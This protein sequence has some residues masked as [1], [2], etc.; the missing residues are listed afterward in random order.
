MNKNKDITIIGA[1]IVGLCSALELQQAGYQ[2]TL[3]DKA[4]PGQGASYGNAGIISPWSIVPQSL[5]GLWRKLP[6]W[7]LDPNGPVTVRPGYLPRMAYWGIRFLMNGH[8]KKVRTSAALMRGLVADCIPLYKQLLNN[9][10][11]E[12]LIKDAYYVQAFRNANDATLEAL[13]YRI[14]AEY[15]ANLARINSQELRNLEPA[16]SHDFQAAILIKDQARLTNPG[17]LGEVLKQKFLLTGGQLSAL[18]VNAIRPDQQGNWIYEAQGRQY[19]TNKLLLC[20]GAWSADLLKTIKVKVML[21]NERGYHMSFPGL[22]LQLNHSV[23]DADM[24][25]VAS[26]MESGLRIAGTAE[27]DHKEA[28]I[29]E[30]RAMGLAELAS[31]MFPDL[32]KNQA[33]PWVGVRPSMPD[34]LPCIGSVKGNSGLYVAFGHSHYGMM[35]APKTGQLITQHIEG[36]LPA[37]ALKPFNL[38]RY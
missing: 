15:G 28:P 26:Q 2:V 8:T 31:R 24:K 30:E 20:A 12:N 9:S 16:L 3:I 7:L 27:F 34:S 37:E 25:F 13:D 14:R 18:H 23:M 22:D 17:R 11:A 4:E 29:N 19:T 33:Q 10:G 36:T 1:G 21:Q 6:G 38:D 32:D 35:M 5:P